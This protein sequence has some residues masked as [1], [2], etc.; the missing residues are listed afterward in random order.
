MGCDTCGADEAPAH[1]VDLPAFSIDRTEVTQRA[2][3]ACVDAGACSAPVDAPTYDPVAR[4]DHPVTSM[5]WDD[6]VAYCAF[7]GERLPSEAEW[8]KAARGTD[9]RRYP[10]GDDDATCA[11]ANTAGCTADD[12]DL[13]VGSLPDGASPFGA[14]DMAGNVWEWTADV[15]AADAYATG[16]VPSTGASRTYRGGGSGNTADLAT[17]TNRADTYNPAVGGS[18]L[19]FRCARDG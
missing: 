14:L 4:G 16:A 1:A 19:G 6:A 5:T 11:L 10:W 2:Y 15:Y 13:P 17:T 18:G 8:E 12:D 7:A 3:Q 9:G